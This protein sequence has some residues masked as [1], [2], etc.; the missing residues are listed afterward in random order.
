MI[1]ILLAFVRKELLQIRRNKMMLLVIFLIPVVQLVV[2]V[3]AA[4]PIVK[5]IALVVVDSDQ[6]NLSKEI[7]NRCY[8]SGYFKRVEPLLSSRQAKSTLERGDA[9]VILE[10]PSSFEREL[11][12]GRSPS[13]MISADAVN[14]I[15]GMLAVNYLQESLLMS[16]KELDMRF[17]VNRNNKP[18][19]VVLTY[20]EWYNPLRDHKSH[21]LPGILGMLLTVIAIMLSSVNIVRERE[22]GNIEQIN[23]TPISKVTF[24]LGKVIP[25]GMLGL[26]QF[27]IGL[28]VIRFGFSVPIEGSV[29]LLYCVAV[30]YLSLLLSIGFLISELSD[31]QSQAMFTTLFLIFIFVLMSGLL[32]PVESMPNWAQLI[33]RANPLAYMVDIMRR[34]VLKGAGIIDLWHEIVVLILFSLSVNMI[35][36]MNYRKSVN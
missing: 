3:F 23:V 31:N 7:T 36:I 32:T 20:S 17:L 18:E 28:L 11:L 14:G 21:M 15:K 16:M 27:T 30:I 2:L 6:S 5:N 10:F 35:A 13:V 24:I 19:Q 22:K 4:N 34:I 33:N 25:Y 9:D 12:L 8:S 26:V 1:Y 29:V